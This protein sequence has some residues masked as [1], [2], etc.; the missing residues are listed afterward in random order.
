MSVADAARY[1]GV[2][3]KV[4]YQLI[5]YDRVRTVRRRQVLMVDRQSL[6]EFQRTGQMT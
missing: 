4:V 6:E 2:G 5:E 1:L 3:R